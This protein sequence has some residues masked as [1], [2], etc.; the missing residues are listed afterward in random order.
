M[1]VDPRDIDA[2]WL[3]WHASLDSIIS[4]CRPTEITVL[5]LVLEG[6]FE[7]QPQEG[8]M[9]QSRR[10]CGSPL[11]CHACSGSAFSL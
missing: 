2:G 11:G 8:S 5:C 1:V 3:V 9:E 10:M 4:T 7:S 6:R